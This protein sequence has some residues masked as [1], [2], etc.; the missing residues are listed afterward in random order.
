MD[1]FGEKYVQSMRSVDR[2]LNQYAS[3]CDCIVPQIKRR[4]ATIA[5]S[6]FIYLAQKQTSSPK[7]IKE[8]LSDKLVKEGFRL[9]DYASMSKGKL[10][11]CC[12]VRSRNYW[13]IDKV[14]RMR[15]GTK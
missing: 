12:V 5:L 15:F 6:R 10:L 2:V 3:K 13:L 8:L 1:L 11:F 4:A 7:V 14:L 9:L